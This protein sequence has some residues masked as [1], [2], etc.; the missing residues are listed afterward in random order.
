MN[1]EISVRAI[2]SAHEQLQCD[3]QGDHHFLGYVVRLPGATI[4][5]SGDCVPY[6]GLADALARERIDLALLPV[7]GRDELRRS[8]GILGNFC[9]PEAVSLC[10]EAG[11]DAMIACHYGMFDFNTVDPAWLDRQIGD[12]PA[13]LQCTRAKV[14]EAYEILEA[15]VPTMERISR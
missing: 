12:L 1:A 8:Q 15:P 10:R 14:D 11:I 5:H 3:E 6:A 9:F 4:Y 7:N 13:T 2:A